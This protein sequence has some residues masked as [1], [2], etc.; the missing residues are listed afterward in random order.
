VRWRPARL[1]KDEGLAHAMLWLLRERSPTV[2]ARVLPL[3]RLAAELGSEEAERILDRLYNQ[4]IADTAWAQELEADAAER[5]LGRRSGVDRRV[6]ERRKIVAAGLAAR[7]ERRESVERR[8][9][10][11]RREQQALSLV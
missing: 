6:G 5:P 2:E 7:V 10:V 9:G 4:T 1:V 8:A 3:N 11:D